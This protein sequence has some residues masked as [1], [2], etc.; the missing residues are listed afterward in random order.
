MTDVVVQ[1]L[2]TVSEETPSCVS[3]NLYLLWFRL[4]GLF[5]CEVVAFVS[6]DLNTSF[7]NLLSGKGNIGLSN[8]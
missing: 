8:Q 4:L 1:F 3:M 2:L 7:H 5:Q 6:K